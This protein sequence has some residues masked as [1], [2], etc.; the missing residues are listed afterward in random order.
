MNGL[1]GVQKV[2]VESNM[3]MAL[4][5]LPA[6]YTISHKVGCVMCAGV[7]AAF[8]PLKQIELLGGSDFI[9]NEKC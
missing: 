3:Q 8:I 7:F 2:V 9:L 4:E 5:Y 6:G 1:T